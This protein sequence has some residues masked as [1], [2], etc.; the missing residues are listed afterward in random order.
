MASVSVIAGDTVLCGR[1]ELADT[2]A[3]RMR[4][5]LGRAS[6]EPGEGILLKPAP[7]IHTWFMR[8]P[9]DAVFVDAQLEVVGIREDVRPWR[10]VRAKGARCV[11]ELAAGESRRLGIAT[12]DRLELAEPAPSNAKAAA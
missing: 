7:A 11:I 4:G 8:F 12:G 10:F 6:L 1:C 3:R 9:I 5:L 2:A